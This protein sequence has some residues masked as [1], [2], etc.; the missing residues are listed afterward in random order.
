MSQRRAILLVQKSD[1]HSRK[2]RSVGR[3]NHDW[4]KQTI[5]YAHV[6]DKTALVIGIGIRRERADKRWQSEVIDWVTIERRE[7][8]GD[9]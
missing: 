9:W 6:L 2:I 7:E 1:S 3:Y 5:N 8:A 4:K